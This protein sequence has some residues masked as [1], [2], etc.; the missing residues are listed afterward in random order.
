MHHAYGRVDLHSFMRVGAAGV[1]LFFVISGFIM[2]TVGPG[3]QPGEFLLDR[4]WR[5]FP[6]WLIAVAPW[7]LGQTHDGATILTSLT[8]WPVWNGT[9]H[10]PAL[11]LGW[12]LCFEMLFYAAFA[13]ALATRPAVP[14]AAFALCLLL[15]VR[16]GVLAY[17][18]SPLIIEFL[19]GVAIA[20]LPCT[21]HS[22][23]LIAAGL[24]WFALAPP[25]YY[26]EL[27]GHGAWLRLL[28]WGIPAALIVYGARSMEGLFR[29]RAFD[30][31]VLI[32]N[33]SFSI[34]L[35]HELV[36]SHALWWP[37]AV[38]VSVAFGLAAYW[39]VERRIMRLK[40]RLRPRQ[41]VP[42]GAISVESAAE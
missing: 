5:I 11:M 25:G 36:V 8:L 10:T 22:G 14:I 31:A 41:T 12:T 18:G 35:F 38:T 13:I 7:L 17:V 20:R 28:A 9:F 37:A 27:F 39:F 4:A 24:A 1:D 6:M 33:A 15:G 30:S 26:I 42:I 2:A 34:Y 29:H 16:T 32:G 19:A 40:P 21:R 23:I 3:R